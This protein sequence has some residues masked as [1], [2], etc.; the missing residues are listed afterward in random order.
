MP[1]HTLWQTQ[2]ISSSPSPRQPWEIAAPVRDDAFD[3]TSTRMTDYTKRDILHLEPKAKCPLKQSSSPSRWAN[4][5]NADRNN[6]STGVFH[7]FGMDSIH[8]IRAPAL[9]HCLPRKCFYAVQILPLLE[10]FINLE[11]NRNVTSGS[12][13]SD[14]ISLVKQ[15][16]VRRYAAKTTNGSRWSQWSWFMFSKCHLL[17]GSILKGLTLKSPSPIGS[18]CTAQP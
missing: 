6:S 4:R 8:Y 14:T 3:N 18:Q 16:P 10:L 1:K 17:N 13:L 9:R 11:W 5:F 15:S 7:N 12:P 2:G